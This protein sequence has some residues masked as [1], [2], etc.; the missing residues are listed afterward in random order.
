MEIDH[1]CRAGTGCT[2]PRADAQ[3]GH[4]SSIQA[5]DSRIW[6]LQHRVPLGYCGT[7]V[8][9]QV[10]KV[11]AAKGTAE[12]GAFL[13]GQTA[14][15]NRARYVP[16]DRTALDWADTA[17]L[18]STTAGL[19]VSRH[20]PS[21]SGIYLPGS[22]ARLFFGGPQG[23]LGLGGYLGDPSE[24]TSEGL[25][26]EGQG[27][28]RAGR[29]RI[30]QGRSSQPPRPPR[31]LLLFLGV[32]V[33]VSD[34]APPGCLFSPAAVPGVDDC[35]M[36]VAPPNS[37]Q[38]QPP[39]LGRQRRFFNFLMM[40]NDRTSTSTSGTLFLVAATDGRGFA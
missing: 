24:G 28:G 11:Q 1:R 35:I 36:V 26:S 16:C 37:D 29:V 33:S 40:M 25:N 20:V 22:S 12:R 13:I 21:K 38:C 5:S 8:S 2:G 3:T 17:D 34:S 31:P 32:S 9:G 23:I 7:M 18:P 19:Q 27:K 6:G 10:G 39:T 30:G 4:F 15:L 14:L